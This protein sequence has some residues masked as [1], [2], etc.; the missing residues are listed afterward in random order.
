MNM[1][2]HE[3]VLPGLVN[4]WISSFSNRV[5]WHFFY[6]QTATNNTDFHSTAA[7][8]TPPTAPAPLAAVDAAAIHTVYT[9]CI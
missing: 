8:H 2:Y 6:K 1:N 5:P 9:T 4:A 3:I 7:E